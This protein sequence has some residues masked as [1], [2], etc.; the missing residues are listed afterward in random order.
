M[1]ALSRDPIS[2][3]IVARVLNISQVFD[4]IWVI[5]Q[6]EGKTSNNSNAYR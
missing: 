1:H 4:S 3:Q 2:N 6:L 5:K